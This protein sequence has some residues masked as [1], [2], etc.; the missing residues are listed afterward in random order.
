MAKPMAGILDRGSGIPEFATAKV[1]TVSRRRSSGFGGGAGAPVVDPWS[2][3]Q[4]VE[5]PVLIPSSAGY[6]AAVPSPFSITTRHT[7]DTDESLPTAVAVRSATIPLH[8]LGTA[9]LLH[10]RRRRL[11]ALTHDPA[12]TG[13]SP[14]MRLQHDITIVR[15]TIL[16]I[17]KQTDPT[18][19]RK[20]LTEDELLQVAVAIH[21]AE[22]REVC[23]STARTWLS[24]PAERL[25]LSVTRAV[26]APYSADA[27][28]LLAYSA[29]TR[30]D[31]VLAR[32]AVDRAHQADPDHPLAAA[33]TAAL[34]D[35]TDP[36][37]F[38][39]SSA[40]TAQFRRFLTHVPP[41]A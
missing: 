29:Y 10:R 23:L 19:N 6:S 16:A 5:A 21:D 25:W 7:L 18:T 40:V 2:N 11:H 22:V 13:L 30:L 32:R 27:A 39:P 37:M 38:A 33:V 4:P 14:T 26:P 34:D 24:R 31:D 36:G 17:G 1:N 12:R 41:R 20:P 8:P 3:Q 28:S 15:H 35:R 9:D